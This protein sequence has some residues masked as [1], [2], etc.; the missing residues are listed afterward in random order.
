MTAEEKVKKIEAFLLKYESL[1]NGAEALLDLTGGSFASPLGDAVARFLDLGTDLLSEV[2]QDHGAW[3][4]WFIAENEFGRK[5]LK[6]Y[7]GGKLVEVKTVDDLVRVM[8][9]AV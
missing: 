1:L 3:V 8:E 7:S 4:Y 2:L 6:A 5:G 9:N